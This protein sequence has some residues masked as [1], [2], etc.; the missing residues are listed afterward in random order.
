MPKPTQQTRTDPDESERARSGPDG[1]ISWRVRSGPEYH[2]ISDHD[3]YGRARLGPDHVISWL[4]WSGPEYHPISTNINTKKNA[5][6]ISRRI[7]WQNAE[8][9]HHVQTATLGNYLL[10]VR[11]VPNQANTFPQRILWY[12]IFLITSVFN[13]IVHVASL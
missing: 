2:P 1:D 13:T 11:L 6:E 3:E 8:R 12:V 10:S 5:T 4:V 9:P 7:T